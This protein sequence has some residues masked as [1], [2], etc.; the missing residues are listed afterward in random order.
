MQHTAK[1]CSTLQHIAT[2]CSWPAEVAVELIE[3]GGGGLV[4]VEKK[5]ERWWVMRGGFRV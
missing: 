5:K 4:F 3:R 2:R 1:H